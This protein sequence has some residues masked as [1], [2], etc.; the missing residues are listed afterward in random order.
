MSRQRAS[1]RKRPADNPPQR[2]AIPVQ[3]SEAIVEHSGARPLTE[4]ERATLKAAVDTLA[5]ITTSDVPERTMAA[6]AVLQLQTTVQPVERLPRPDADRDQA[7]GIRQQPA[8]RDHQHM[9]PGRLR[10]WPCMAYLS[11][12]LELQWSNHD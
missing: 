3:E 9:E 10:N 11:T 12:V 1:H 4:T 2:M 7:I 6:N 5:R 8:H